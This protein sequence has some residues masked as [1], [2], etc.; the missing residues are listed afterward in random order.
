MF[1]MLGLFL[2]S[3]I[4][5]TLW[6]GAGVARRSAAAPMEG[7]AVE[8]RGTFVGKRGVHKGAVYFDLLRRTAGGDG[9][10]AAAAGTG[11]HKVREGW[12][13]AQRCADSLNPKP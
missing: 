1:L 10:A 12:T 3:F 5:A 6:A 13:R 7:S 11:P 4:E 8:A 2:D 9:D